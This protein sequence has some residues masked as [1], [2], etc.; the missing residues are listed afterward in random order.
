MASLV[1]PLKVDCVT[2]ERTPTPPS[3]LTPHVREVVCEAGASY[4]SPGGR[5]RPRGNRMEIRPRRITQPGLCLG[6]TEQLSKVHTCQ[7]SEGRR[8]SVNPI[9]QRVGVAACQFRLIIDLNGPPPRSLQGR[10]LT[11]IQNSMAHCLFNHSW[12]DSLPP[13]PL[14]RSCVVS[15]QGSCI[16][17]GSFHGSL[18]L[19]T[20]TLFAGWASLAGA[21]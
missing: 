11:A 8:L 20:S 21:V 13:K 3:P 9:P 19:H 2:Q 4:S 5:R 12:P 14:F 15:E 6:Y 17:P 18:L 10:R 16:H 1:R 7:G